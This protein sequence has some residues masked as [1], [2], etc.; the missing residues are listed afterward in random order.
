LSKTGSGVGL[1]DTPGAQSGVTVRIADWGQDQ[2]ILRSIRE[3]VFVVEQRV[4][5]ALEWDGLDP[6][7]THVIACAKDG[8]A[9]GTARLL[10]DG[11][12]GRMA[13]LRPWRKRGVGSCMLVALIGIA[14]QRGK[15]RCA[16]NAQT[17]AIAFYERHGF[18]A[19]GEE[20]DDAGIAHRHMVLAR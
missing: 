17:H 1:L 11:H 14:R 15:L 18:V 19:E 20:F 9:V 8:S 2:A 4:P 3:Q 12:I 16:L 6:V 10:K 5:V 7:C 13:V